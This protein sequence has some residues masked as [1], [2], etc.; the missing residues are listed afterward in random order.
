LRDLRLTS[1]PP[2]KF[3]T[4]TTAPPRRSPSSSNVC[5]VAPRKASATRCGLSNWGG[6]GWSQ[7]SK[8]GTHTHTHTHTQAKNTKKTR[9]RVFARASRTV[10][11]QRIGRDARYAI[12]RWQKHWSFS[13]AHWYECAPSQPLLPPQPPTTVPLYLTGQRMRRFAAVVMMLAQRVVGGTNGQP[14][15][16]PDRAP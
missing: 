12:H 6:G 15:L 9:F 14:P 4:H 10:A 3:D 1:I 5:S 7:M 11:V 8:R 13:R 16:R 2:S